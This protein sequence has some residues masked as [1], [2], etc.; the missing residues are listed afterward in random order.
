MKINSILALRYLNKNRKR[1]AST[2]LRSHTC[3]NYY[4]DII[5]YI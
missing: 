3:R 4:N 5:N 1:T 2:I